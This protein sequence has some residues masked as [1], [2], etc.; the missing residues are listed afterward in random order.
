MLVVAG[1]G[2]HTSTTVLGAADGG[3][4]VAITF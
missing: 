4:P 3:R 2:E 1:G